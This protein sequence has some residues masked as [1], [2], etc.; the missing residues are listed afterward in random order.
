MS[1]Y[2][3]ALVLDAGTL[4]KGMTQLYANT[5]ARQKFFQGNE[6]I[7][8]M[9]LV[10][11][12]WSID[13]A[14]QFLLAPPTPNQW[15]DKHTFVPSGGTK[16]PQPT[17]QMFQVQL[18]SVTASFHLQ[19]GTVSKM[20]FAFTVFAQVTITA[21]RH[22][23]LGSVAVLPINPTAM[24]DFMLQVI[25]GIV[26]QKVQGLLQGYQIPASISVE[27]Q[28]FTPPVVTVTGSHLVLACN[29]VANGTPD[30]GGVQWPQN[31]LGVLIGRRLLSALLQKYSSALIQQ[32]SDKKINE[33][34]SNWSG[35]Y[36]LKGGITNPSVAL[37]STLPNVNITA[38]FAATAEV[39][40]SWWL[41]PAA[42]A[43][44]AAS[45][46]LP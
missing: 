5:L 20:S 42:C 36:S 15:N 2:D 9:G 27:G 13:T 33:S 16:P 41:V 22:V 3:A 31:P 17:D 14:P 7:G 6:N 11:V 39:G 26:Y 18:A 43:L 35:S 19:D 1:S 21:D 8:Q 30:I 12:D 46:L 24:S 45:N 44:E 29:L 4:N 40:V 25:C 38:T 34:D 37:A 23:Q 32:M 10:S 28:D